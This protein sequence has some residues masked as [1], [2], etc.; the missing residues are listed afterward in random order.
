MGHSDRSLED[1]PS[2]ISV[3]DQLKKLQSRTTSATG[4]EAIPVIC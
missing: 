4:L 2:E 1:S 3:E